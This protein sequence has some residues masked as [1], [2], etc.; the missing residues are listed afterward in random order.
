[1]YARLLTHCELLKRAITPFEKAELTV[2]I[3]GAL[4]WKTSRIARL[5]KVQAGRSREHARAARQRSLLPP[6]LSRAGCKSAIV[7]HLCTPTSAP[8]QHSRSIARTSACRPS[9]PTASTPRGPGPASSRAARVELS[10]Q[11]FFSLAP[12]LSPPP[13]KTSSSFKMAL[14]TERGTPTPLL[15]EEQVSKLE[16]APKGAGQPQ[17]Q[18]KYT[19][20]LT[21]L[22]ACL[23][24]CASACATNPADIIKVGFCSKG[25]SLC[26]ASKLT[27]AGAG[28]RCANNC[29]VTRPAAFS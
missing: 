17:Q 5:C 23:G 4:C 1:M 10:H 13:L 15:E 28:R 14:K 22:A 24:A 25:A 27:C 26:V 6:R 11:V 18:G 2:L 8:T 21:F 16:H 3:E 20:S 12:C 9:E 29:C 19:T 7:K